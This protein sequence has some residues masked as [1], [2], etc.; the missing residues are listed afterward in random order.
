MDW[1][2]GALVT[3]WDGMGIVFRG[4]GEEEEEVCGGGEARVMV[5]VMVMLS[6][7]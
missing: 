2:V 3:G 1:I 5:V 4:G 7:V 6:E